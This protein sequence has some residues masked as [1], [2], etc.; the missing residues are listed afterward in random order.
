MC[1]LEGKELFIY[2]LFL[3]ISRCPE[4]VDLCILPN[5]KGQ[6]I[7]LHIQHKLIQA[8]CWEND[9]EIVELDQEEFGGLTKSPRSKSEAAS[10]VE[11][12]LVT[13]KPLSEVEIEADDIEDGLRED[14][15]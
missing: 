3:F 6:D 13:S 9:I 5:G 15:G 8:F 12:I 10:G 14:F 2:D 1:F 7:S 4:V 11:C